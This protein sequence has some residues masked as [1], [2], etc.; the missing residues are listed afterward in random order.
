M[1]DMIGHADFI[2]NP[3]GLFQNISTEFADLI[4]KPAEG[5]VKG[6]LERGKGI[7]EGAGSFAQKS[8]TSAL[9][10]GIASL[11]QVFKKF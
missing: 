8:F 1:F 11:F 2:G 6:P 4:E 7:F 9:S 3:I 5:F 10:T